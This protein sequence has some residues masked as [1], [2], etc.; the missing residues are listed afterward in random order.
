MGESDGH[1]GVEVRGKAPSTAFVVVGCTKVF[2]KDRKLV[3]SSPG[4]PREYEL[5]MTVA[6]SLFG[7]VPKLAVEDKDV[8]EGPAAIFDRD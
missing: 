8:R 5:A 4:C 3:P 2:T 7:G 1:S 6:N